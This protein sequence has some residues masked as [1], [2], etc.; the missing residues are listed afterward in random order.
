MDIDEI[1]ALVGAGKFRLSLHAE[2]ET[3]ADNLHISEIVTAIL[4]DDPLE[5]YPDTGRGESC[6]LLG[7]VKDIPLHVVCGFRAGNVIII[8]VYIPTLPKFVDP[9]TRR[10]EE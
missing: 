7:F 2:M 1:K 8:T 9:W 3:A 6:L 10:T 5:K 4:N